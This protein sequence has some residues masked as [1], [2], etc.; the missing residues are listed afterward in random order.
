MDIVELKQQITDGSISNDF[1]VWILEDESSEIIANQYISKICE[2]K[3]LSPKIIDDYSDIPDQSFSIDSNLYIKKEDKVSEIRKYSNCILL[4]KKC[5]NKDSIKIPKLEDWQV[6]DYLHV[7]TPGL[8]K[9]EI[10]WLATQYNKN[11]Q[12]MINDFDKISIFSENLQDRVYK[13]LLEDGQFDS[14]TSLNIWDLTN[15]ILRKDYNLVHEVLVRIKFIDIEPIGL[16]TTLYNGFKRVINIQLNPDVTAEDLGISGKQF[17]VIKKYNCGHYTKEQ[18]IKI[19]SILTNLEYR[20][21]YEGIE[22]N[23]LVDYMIVNILGV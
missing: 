12:R 7:K 23:Q 5:N 19:F 13:L 1:M 20:Y 3:N 21:K 6:I 10:E 22:I 16:L 18:L 14:V 17:F 15:G 4:C 8:D 9:K 11:Y 2:L